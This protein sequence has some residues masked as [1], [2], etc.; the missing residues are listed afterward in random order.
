MKSLA[1]LQ[2]N[3]IIAIPVMMVLGFITG[4][5]TDVSF[6]KQL[7]LPL[8]FLV[9]YPMMVPLPMKKLLE[10]GDAKVQTTAQ[11]L[12]FAVYPFIAFGLGKLFFPG[13]DFLVI[14]LLLA[15]LL[16][17]SGM[18]I[19]WT[20]MAKGNMPAAVKMTIVGLL[21]GSILT[22]IYLQML[23]G[24][25]VKINFVQIVI[26]IAVVVLI[27][28]LLGML[29]QNLLVKKYGMAHFNE[30][31]KTQFPP[32]STLGVLAIVFVAISLKAKNI[33]EDP[34]SLV[35]IFIPLIILYTL[36][37]V[38]SIIVG[39][40]LFKRG[41]A[42]A[43]LYGTVMRNLSI[44]LAIAMTA[45]DREAGAEIALVI[46]L[47]YIVQVQ[48]A[49]WSVKLTAKIYGP[50]PED[51]ASQIMHYG[52]FALHTEQ[53]MAEA[54]KLF[55]Y[56]HIHSLV[57]LD[58]TDKPVG[59]LTQEMVITALVEGKELATPL[60]VFPLDP[61]VTVDPAMPVS[62]ILKKMNS[63]HEYKVLV[64]NKKGLVQGVVTAHDILED[65][66]KNPVKGKK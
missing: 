12:N 45:F 14:G 55:A 10:G 51:T 16:P 15:G 27:P 33:A 21:V 34:A 9:V 4:A 28:L 39:K 22:P 6:L 65:L 52:I 2:K 64:T 32:F 57:V 54:E 1:W 7:V 48:M 62:E 66:V 40:L 17:T 11:I 19:S 8:T 44:A 35:G 49:A 60:G 13:N 47:A 30:K 53:T 3:L 43:L 26:Q 25:T 58:D 31:I 29:T 36:N 24:A 37:F 38:I 59:M 61:V 41:D 46:A 18:T 50:A 20:G 56:E 5:S 23:M 63:V 42:I